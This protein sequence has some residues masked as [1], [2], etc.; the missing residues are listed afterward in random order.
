MVTFLLTCNDWILSIE[1]WRLKIEG[2]LSILNKTER[3]DIHSASGGSINNLQFSIPACPGQVPFWYPEVRRLHMRKPKVKLN[4]SINMADQ[5]VLFG[6]F[7]AFLYWGLESFLNVFSPE[8]INFYRQIF[9]SN[10]SEIWMRLIVIC[11]DCRSGGC[12]WCP[13]HQARLQGGLQP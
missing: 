7:L 6:L 4:K 11:P 2:I 1:D 13:D 5:M 12:L 10:V 8:E 3:S 9:G